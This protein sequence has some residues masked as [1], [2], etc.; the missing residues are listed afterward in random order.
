MKGPAME[1]AKFLVKGVWRSSTV[2]RPVFNP[3]QNAPAG[4]VCQASTKDIDDAIGAAEDAFQATK[5][6]SAFSRSAILGAVSAGIEKRKDE[7][8]RMITSETGKPI[9]FS[10]AEVDRSIFNFATAAEEAKRIGGYVLPLDVAPDNDNR[11]AIVRRFPLGVIG[12]ITPFNFPL[13][14]VAHKLGPAIAAGNTVVLKPSSNAPR[15]ALLLGEV[16]ESTP[17]PKGAINIVPCMGSEAEQLITDKRVKMLSF[18]GSP[19]VGWGIKSRAG[20]KRVMLE[21]GGNAGVIVAA[22]A[23]LDY[24]IKRILQGAFGNAGQSC[25]SVQRVYVHESVADRFTEQFV[26]MTK[27]IAVGDPMN[28]RTIVGPMIDEQ[29]AKKIESW[30]AEAVQGGATLLTGG[31]RK[32]AVLEPTIL[33]NVDPTLKVSCQE[34]FAPLVTIDRFREFREAVELV[35]ASMFG[36][37]AGIFTNNAQDIFYAYRELE[38]GGVIVNDASNYRMDHMPYGGVKESGMG[39]EGIRSAIEE[40]TETKLLAL[41]FS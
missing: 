35:N 8:A 12:A 21:L 40:M 26:K 30:I 23:N 19:M 29:A 24:A 27:S 22:D 2:K 38:V 3:F 5:K 17:L 1:A 7:F 33:T 16:F 37:Q 25:I 32:G 39:R 28:E 41:N 36:L 11:T 18:T 34:V 20:K 6:L 14:L 31:T 10:R 4:E 9:T 13:N 15:T